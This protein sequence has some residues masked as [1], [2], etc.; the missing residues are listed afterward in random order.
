MCSRGCSGEQQACAFRSC[1]AE[2][3]GSGW[4]R[5]PR[6]LFTKWVFKGGKGQPVPVGF[7]PGQLL[8][9]PLAESFMINKAFPHQL[10]LNHLAAKKGG[11]D[12]PLSSL[13]SRNPRIVPF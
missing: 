1:C 7:I 2:H 6:R 8:T 12:S 13:Q 4:L 9:C 11:Q 5:K 3:G 10:I